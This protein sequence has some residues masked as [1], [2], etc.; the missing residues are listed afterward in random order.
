MRHPDLDVNNITDL[1]SLLL[2][3]G[4]LKDWLPTVAVI[5]T[6]FWSL[7]RIFEWVRFRLFRKHDDKY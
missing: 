7:I 6:I 3:L 4:V 5:L 2:L 1:A